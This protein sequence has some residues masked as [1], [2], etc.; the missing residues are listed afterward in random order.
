MPCSNQL[1]YFI[2]TVSLHNSE[3]DPR[4]MYKALRSFSLAGLNICVGKF[5]RFYMIA[6]RIPD[7]RCGLHSYNIR[8]ALLVIPYKA[9]WSSAEHMLSLVASARYSSGS[10]A[11]PNNIEDL[12]HPCPLIKVTRVSVSDVYLL[13]VW[14]PQISVPVV[15]LL[16]IWGDLDVGIRCLLARAGIS[17]KRPGLFQGF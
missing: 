13:V 17:L 16:I 10:P 6:I 5:Y 11:L 3:L 9:Q 2:S 14:V 7:L 15:S 4:R 12:L 1:P 8:A